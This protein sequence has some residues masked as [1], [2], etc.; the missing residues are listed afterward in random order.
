MMISCNKSN[1]NMQRKYLFCIAS[2]FRNL[3]EVSYHRKIYEMLI[4]YAYVIS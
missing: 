3:N 4:T 2:C 1:K